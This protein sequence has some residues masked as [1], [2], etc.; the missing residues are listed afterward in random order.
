MRVMNLYTPH[1]EMCDDPPRPSVAAAR[2]PSVAT[3]VL[4]ALFLLARI[5]SA[6]AESSEIGPAT[7]LEPRI[8]GFLVLLAGFVCPSGWIRC[9]S[10]NSLSNS[11][12]SRQN[13]V[14]VSISP[15][16]VIMP[17]LA[18]LCLCCPYLVGREKDTQATVGHYDN[19]Y[20]IGCIV[21]LV[22]AWERLKTLLPIKSIASSLTSRPKYPSKLM[23]IGC[24]LDVRQRASKTLS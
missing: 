22:L 10:T 17:M 8:L 3:K 2:T 23:K 20:L 18:V 7:S 12:S 16:L 6:H 14:T 21:T 11:E 4:I 9:Q 19:L 15:T 13:G 1:M 5:R 24:L